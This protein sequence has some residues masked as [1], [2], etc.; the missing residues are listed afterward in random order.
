[1]KKLMTGINIL[2][3]L[4][5]AE[6]AFTACSNSD[7]ANEQPV[8]SQKAYTLTVNASKGNE[9]ITRAL[10]LS[11][12]TLNATWSVGDEVKVYNGDTE[13]GTLTAQN[14]GTNTTLTGSLTTAPN[15]N[16]ELTLKFLSP[17]YSAQEGTL[18]YIAANC[19]YAVATVTVNTVNTTEKTITTTGNADFHNQQAIVK[20][21][22]TD[23]A[24]TPVDISKLT[25]SVSTIRDVYTGIP[26]WNAY[27]ITPV[28]PTNELY[29]AIPNINNE[30]IN[31][32]A[33]ND[34]KNFIYSKQNVTFTNGLFYEIT[35]KLKTPTAPA[36]VQAIDLGL[37]SG[38]LWANMN[39]GATAPERSGD[40]I[41]WGETTP[42]SE[43][44][45][46]TYKYCNGL[47]ETL[48]KYCNNGIYGY[49]GYTDDLT[50][51]ETTDDAAT[52]NWGNEWRTPTKDEYN[53]LINNT[54]I[55]WVENYNETSIK[56]YKITNKNDASKYIFLP[57]AGWIRTGIGLFSFNY[58][59]SYMTSTLD[60]GLA[61][62]A[63]SLYIDP[64]Q[65]YPANSSRFASFCL[66]PVRR[67]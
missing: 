10:S 21:T 30:D 4:L 22:L 13:I 48:T 67:N 1:M 54:N 2:V 47:D 57:A 59:V 56:G 64:S 25:L 3:A 28:S 8:L 49:N 7:D 16:D 44:E 33:S 35:V 37:P 66:R 20:F 52:V 27:V 50:V 19:D 45:W 5:I 58:T 23:N 6:A 55:E 9:A 62:N 11:G 60:L 63:G 18:E 31:L 17:D 36:G 40:Y 42:K 14:S 41:A 12:S 51:L 46:S 32:Y 61:V 34:S 39:V 38:K 43:Y 65:I 53:E 29:I 15:V 26:M 24:A